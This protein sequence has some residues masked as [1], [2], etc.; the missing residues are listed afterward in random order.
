MPLRWAAKVS[1]GRGLVTRFGP[2]LK[3]GKAA[4]RVCWPGAGK[5]GMGRI[6]LA[7]TC[8]GV[9]RYTP[10]PGFANGAMSALQPSPR[11]RRLPKIHT[12]GMAWRVAS[13]EACTQILAILRFLW[14]RLSVTL[15]QR[16]AACT[17]LRC[18]LAAA[19]CDQYQTPVPGGKGVHGAGDPARPKLRTASD[20][21]FPQ[22]GRASKKTLNNV[23]WSN[24][25]GC[26]PKRISAKTVK[27]GAPPP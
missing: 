20:R 6:P 21:R 10:R 18:R 25:N 12:K 1:R 22:G 5:Q 23:A 13:R 8:P 24:N 27:L 19:S 2:C 3:H 17:S 7:H 26:E 14:G 16:R 4:K 15:P 11:G 9:V